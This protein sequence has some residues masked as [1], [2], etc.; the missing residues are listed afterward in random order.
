MKR[1]AAALLGLRVE[2]GAPVEIE[3]VRRSVML[4]R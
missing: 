2:Q 4:D 3:E 1:I